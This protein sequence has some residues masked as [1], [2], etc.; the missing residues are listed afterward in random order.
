MEMEELS[1]LGKGWIRSHFVGQTFL[2]RHLIRDILSGSNGRY[3]P[4]SEADYE[5]INRLAK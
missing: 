4:I 3:E 5:E 2:D 1:P